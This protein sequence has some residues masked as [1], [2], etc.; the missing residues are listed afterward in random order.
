MCVAKL[1][2]MSDLN[3]SPLWSFQALIES[4]PDAVVVYDLYNQV[5]YLNSAAQALYGWTV[6]EMEKRSLTE[7]FYPEQGALDVAVQALQETGSWT[8]ELQQVGRNCEP[9]A[10]WSRQQIVA[11]ATG[12]PAL[13]VCFNT[14]VTESQPLKDSVQKNSSVQINRETLHDLSN[15]IA[16]IVLSSDILKRMITDGKARSMVSM[17]EKSANKCTALV[18][19]LLA[20][21]SLENR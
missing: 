20:G 12:A 7:I 4:A 11:G 14:E 2:P 9:C 1:L 3:E 19:K 17:M 16:P 8:G 21:E 15:A 5:H 10:V 6:K 13:I 18:A